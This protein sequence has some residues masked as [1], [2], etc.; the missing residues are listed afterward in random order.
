MN[1]TSSVKIWLALL[2]SS[3][4]LSGCSTFSLFGAQSVQPVDVKTTQTEKVRLSIG[5]PAPIELKKVQWF[6]ITPENAEEVFSSLEKKKYNLV[7]FGLTDD[8]Y[9]NLSSNMAEIRA[10]ILK[11]RS[12]V[13]AYKDYYEPQEEQEEQK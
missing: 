7:L 13:K 1:K 4:L 8:G 9:E 5:E 6:V 11:Q 12:T 10:Y 2:L 3:L